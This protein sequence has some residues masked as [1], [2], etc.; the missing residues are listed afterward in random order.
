[1]ST[2]IHLPWTSLYFAHYEKK[3]PLE[4]TD[5]ENSPALYDSVMELDLVL[6][7]YLAKKT[8]IVSSNKS[9]LEAHADFFRLLRKGIFDPYVL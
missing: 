1:M 4:F 8:Y 6:W 5:H 7:I 9:H 2:E 3:C